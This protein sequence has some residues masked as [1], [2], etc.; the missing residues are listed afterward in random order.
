MIFAYENKLDN[1]TITGTALSDL[2]PIENIIEKRLDKYFLGTTDAAQRIVFDCG[3]TVTH[4]LVA[5]LNHNLV[6]GSQTI[7]IQANATD[8]WGA[9]SFT[10]T[11]TVKDLIFGIIDTD[12]YRYWSL[13]IEGCTVS[14]QIGLAFLGDYLDFQDAAKVY[15]INVKSLGISEQSKQRILFGYKGNRVFRDY[16][17]KWDW[18]VAADLTGFKTFFDY[19]EKS[20]PFICIWSATTD[21]VAIPNL[22]AYFPN[23]YII[24]DVIDFENMAMSIEMK[25]TR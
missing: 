13:Y 12:D 14:P 15:P 1:Y 17:L 5:I 7:K 20:L 21:Y 24:D 22:Y 10:Q 18:L 6:S 9:P 11:L 4:T 23:D 19:V 3:S 25:E 2:Y 16:K 8:S